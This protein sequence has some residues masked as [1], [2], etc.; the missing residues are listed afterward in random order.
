MQSDNQRLF[1]G[2]VNR[3][4]LFVAGFNC[5]CFRRAVD[6]ITVRRGNLFHFD[7]DAG[8]ESGQG[9]PPVFIRDK[10]SVVVP[11][12]RAASVCQQEFRA[13]NRR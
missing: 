12:F 3:Y 11:D 6:Q 2:I 9:K 5:N 13:R 10:F 4:G 1:R 8:F 7:R